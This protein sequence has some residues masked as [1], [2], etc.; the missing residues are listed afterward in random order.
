MAKRTSDEIT[1]RVVALYT[2]GMTMKAIEASLGISYTAIR[3][4]LVRRGVDRREKPKFVRFRTVDE[5]FFDVID[6]EEKAYWLGFLMADGCINKSNRLTLLLAAR[7]VDHLHK[8]AAAINTDFPIR[9][10]L[11]FSMGAWREYCSIGVHG[12]EFVAGLI[13][14]GVVHR[15]SYNGKPC[16]LERPDLQRHYWRGMLDGDGSVSKVLHRAR[17]WV[18]YHASFVGTESIVNA[19]ADFIRSRSSHPCTVSQ[20]GNQFS[21]AFSGL[22]ALQ[23]SLTILY[24]DA[25]VYLDRKYAVYQELMLR[26]VIKSRSA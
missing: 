3:N 13:K 6:T 17:N 16:L 22:G 2:G 11:R 25:T 5:T 10:H 8:F 4:G 20:K 24:G 7:D 15:K 14:H 26:P 21:F 9:M 18:G 19:F 1:D 12:A 23:K